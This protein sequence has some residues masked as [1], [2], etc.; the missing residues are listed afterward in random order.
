MRP[1]A[2]ILAGLRTDPRGVALIEFAIVLPFLLL[3]FVG[4]YQL[5]DAVFAYRKVTQSARAVADLTS[6][7]TQVTDAQ[8]DDILGASR[9]ILSP[10]P[11]SSTTLRISQ[12]TISA[13]GAAQVDWSRGRN[14]TP[15]AAGSTFDLPAADRQ[16]NTTILVAD[17]TYNYV[18]AFASTMIGPITLKERVSMYPRKSTSVTKVAA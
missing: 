16:N 9:F 18:P 5:S 6:Q 10:Y 17:V 3:L 4:G 13:T 2:P 11:L 12:V 14:T 1:V 7:Y 8:L 15:L